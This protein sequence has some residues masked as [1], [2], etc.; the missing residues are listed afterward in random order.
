MS[1]K[2]V[3]SKERK[4]LILTLA[5]GQYI[6]TMDPVSSKFLVEEC[7]LDFSSATIRNVLAELEEE[8]FLTHP[9]TSAGRIPTQKGYRFYV[10]HCL[11]ELKLLEEEKKRI[12]SEYDKE[13]L[14]LETLLEKT[15]RVLS[16]V[17]HYT[18]LVSVDGWGNKLFY[19]GTSFIAGYPDYQDLNKIKNILS[20]LDE[21]ERLLKIINR[22][23][24]QRIEIFIGKELPCEE[25]NS[26]SL[27]VSQYHTK[28]GNSGRIA[29]LGPTRMD[30]QRV[31][32]ALDYFSDLLEEVF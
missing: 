3:D 2:S 24:V 22:E 6:K 21:K 1:P 28:H 13:K 12:K 30:Y 25:I 14:E 19:Q 11:T 31:V 29:V 10:D 26:C 23:L 9:H 15:S 4:G 8:G 20:A 5:I 27:V 17:T 16:D 18:S 32:S 7:G